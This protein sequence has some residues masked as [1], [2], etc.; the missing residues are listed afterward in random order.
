MWILCNGHA[1]NSQN[2]LSEK[3][4]CSKIKNKTNNGKVVHAYVFTLCFE[5]PK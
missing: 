1:Q 4:P 2:W 5:N 3:T